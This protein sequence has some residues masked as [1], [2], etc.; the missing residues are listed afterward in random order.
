MPSHQGPGKA[1]NFQDNCCANG[2]LQSF[3][4]CLGFPPL[5]SPVT[6]QQL[7]SAQI[8]KYE[9]IYNGGN[10]HELEKKMHKLPHTSEK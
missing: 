8:K 6:C 10:L 1:A 7:N 3:H 4:S 9:Q 2:I 5:L